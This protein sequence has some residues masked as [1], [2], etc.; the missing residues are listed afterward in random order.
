M[1]PRADACRDVE[2]A[3]ML[4]VLSSPPPPS[5]TARE[6][7]P[8]KRTIERDQNDAA[9]SKAARVSSE[10]I[11]DAPAQASTVQ[12]PVQPPAAPAAPAAVPAAVPIFFHVP[13]VASLT[14][15]QLKTVGIHALRFVGDLLRFVRVQPP[16]S[17]TAPPVPARPSPYAAATRPVHATTADGRPIICTGT[18]VHAPAPVPAST[19]PVAP[20]PTAPVF[21]A[22][23]PTAPIRPLYAAAVPAPAPTTAPGST[24]PERRR[25]GNVGRPPALDNVVYWCVLVKRK[26]LQMSPNS[27]LTMEAA[28]E[29]LATFE[30]VHYRDIPAGKGVPISTF[31]K[32]V[33]ELC[34]TTWTAIG[35]ATDP[36]HAAIVDDST[37]IAAAT[38][39]LERSKIA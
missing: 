37:V 2:A 10:K 17:T 8:K 18:P 30:R 15:A 29:L 5:G 4:L 26:L 3:R 38:H 34:D 16:A 14:D 1:T 35:T 21:T 12:P 33:N 22:P 24:L 9:P 13:P 20:V 11:D 31:R 19:V 7:P 28:I 23:V 27:Q 32:C 39:F 25:G 36:D 6:P